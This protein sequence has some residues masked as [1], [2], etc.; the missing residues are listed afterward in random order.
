MVYNSRNNRNILE[1]K[2][3][4]PSLS[5]LRV[6]EI[7]ETYWNVN[8]LGSNFVSGIVYE[9]IETYWNVNEEGRRRDCPLKE[10]IIETYWNVNVLGENNLIPHE[11]G[12]NR[13]ILECK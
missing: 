4:F 1:C 7:I 10:E 8:C 6:Q 9:I 2:S 3:R 5:Q 12:N 11:V 13:N